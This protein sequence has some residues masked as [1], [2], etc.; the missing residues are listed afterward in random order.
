MKTLITIA[1]LI[2]LSIN[3][4]AQNFGQKTHPMNSSVSDLEIIKYWNNIPES[5]IELF[6][7]AHSI[8][9]EKAKNG[10]YADILASKE[11]QKLIKENNKLLLGGPLLGNVSSQNISIWL[12]TSNPSKVQIELINGKLV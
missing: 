2:G 11:Y 12:R 3:V 1:V 9:S 6:N 5:D 7:V 8:F 10:S 4:F